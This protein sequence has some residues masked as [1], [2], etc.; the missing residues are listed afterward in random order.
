M[1]NAQLITMHYERCQLWLSGPRSKI[2]DVPAGGVFTS[3]TGEAWRKVR[4]DGALS[5]AVHC[6][7]VDDGYRDVFAANAEVIYE[8]SA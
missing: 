8:S 3:I 2:V 5:G 6:E 4:N 1:S 7:R